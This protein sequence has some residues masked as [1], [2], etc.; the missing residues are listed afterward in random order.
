MTYKDYFDWANEYRQQADILSK[1]LAERRKTKKFPT[2]EQ[3]KAFENATKILYE[4]HKECVNTMVILE[5][6]AR[7]IKER[8]NYAKRNTIS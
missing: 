4:M 8:E 1:K 6:K 2:A 7:D 5:E 3:R